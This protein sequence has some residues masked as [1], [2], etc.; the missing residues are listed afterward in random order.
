MLLYVKYGLKGLYI[1]N[2]TFFLTM[3]PFKRD[4]TPFWPMVD[5]PPHIPIWQLVTLALA[6]FGFCLI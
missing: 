6:R 5:P 4:V 2:K 3:R 1:S